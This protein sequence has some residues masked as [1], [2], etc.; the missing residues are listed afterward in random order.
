MP[1]SQSQFIHFEYV[2]GKWLSLSRVPITL[3]GI[4]LM[5]PGYETI[6]TLRR[7]SCYHLRGNPVFPYRTKGN[8]R[9]AQNPASIRRE[10]MSILK[11]SPDDVVE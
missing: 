11:Q 5:Q 10:G 3:T 4:H 6:F 9:I 8:L 1:E 2:I 7:W